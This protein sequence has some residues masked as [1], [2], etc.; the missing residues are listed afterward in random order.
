MSG[1]T[2]RDPIRQAIARN[3][4]DIDPDSRRLQRAGPC[5]IA[6]GAIELG[7]ADDREH[8]LVVASGVHL[9]RFGAGFARF[10]RWQAD[11]EQAPA[12]KQ[13]QAGGHLVQRRPVHAGIG[14]QD[15]ALGIAL[16]ARRGPDRILRFRAKQRLV[17]GKDVAAREAAALQ[18]LSELVDP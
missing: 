6:G 15:L 8:V 1:E 5:G 12:R 14:V 17:A 11:L 16:C 3:R 18:V 2:G 9:K 13:R 7:Q 10:T 4:G